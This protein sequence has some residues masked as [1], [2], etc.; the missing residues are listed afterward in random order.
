VRLGPRS[1]NLSAGEAENWVLVWRMLM[2][3]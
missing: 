3:L 2:G 1:R